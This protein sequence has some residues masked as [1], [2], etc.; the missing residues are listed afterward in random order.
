[1]ASNILSPIGC[2][3]CDDDISHMLTETHIHAHSAGAVL[4]KVDRNGYYFHQCSLGQKHK[5]VTWQHYHCS[6][7]HMKH[8]FSACLQDHYTEDLL[9]TIPPGGGSTILHNI[10]LESGLSCKICGSLLDTQAYRFCLSVWTPVN[11][12]PD[13]THI[14]HLAQWCCSLDHARQAALQVIESLEEKHA[15]I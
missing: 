7:Q 12:V 14:D 15:E 10:V 5:H 3:H 1:M 13:N 4:Q 6:H 11:H 9:H 8:G 2:H